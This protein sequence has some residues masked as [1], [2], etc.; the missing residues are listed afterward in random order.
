MKTGFAPIRFDDYV[1]RHLESNPGCSRKE[2]ADGLKDALSA[3]KK[4]VSCD[5][6]E[7]IWVVGSAVMGYSCFTCITGEAKPDDDYEI[8]EACM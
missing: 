1:E 5:C 4:G 3:Y 8:D 7:P 6:G 2:I